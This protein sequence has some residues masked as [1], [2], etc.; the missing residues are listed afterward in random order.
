MRLLTILLLAVAVQ[1]ADLRVGIIGTDIS[2]VIHFTRI[3]N[4][5]S[6][7]D[8]IAGARVV[9]AYKGGSPDIVSS[10]TRVEGYADELKKVYGVEIVPD[11]P[12]LC[13]K[14][15]AILL[16][17]GDGRIHL[18][19][20]RPVIAAHKPLFIDKPLASTLEDALEI[21]RIAKEAGVPWFSSS[22]LRFGQI[23]TTMKFADATG[24]DVW[25]P[26]PMEEHHHLDLSWYAI[27]PIET[28]YSLMGA[29]CDEVTRIV[30][31]DFATGSDIIVGR[32][33]DG[34]VGTVRT[35]RPSGGYGAVVFRPKQIVQ[36]PANTNVSYVP[37]VKQIVAFF[38]SGQPPVPNEETLEIFVFMDAAQRS[39]EA[40][41]KTMKLRLPVS[42]SR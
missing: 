7:P 25:G 13:A 32:W 22:T 2:H 18:E 24:A 29:G 14:V 11:I 10:R 9:A 19:Q 41:G 4:N 40:G 35:L 26:G 12:A 1:A 39:K 27:H 8:H 17:S 21:Q 42:A 37:L 16:E 28:L 38:Q 34:R 15:D 23:G 30:G 31:G 3:L 6:D 36:S 20:A 33:K 5:A